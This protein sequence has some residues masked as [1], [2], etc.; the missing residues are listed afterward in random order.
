[1]ENDARELEGGR[2]MSAQANRTQDFVVKDLGLADWGRKEIDIAETEMPGLM[3]VRAE[4]GAKQ[5]LKGARVAGS[6]HMTIQSSSPI[7]RTKKKRRCT[8]TSAAT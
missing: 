8:T 7:T 6:L 5:P 4:Y 1:L 3:A 2:A